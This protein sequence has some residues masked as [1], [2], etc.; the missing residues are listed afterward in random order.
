[1]SRL[2]TPATIEAAPES[3]QSL[4]KA[5][6]QQLGVV[7]NLFRL[8]AVNP[9]AL[10]G[11]LGLSGALS[12]GLLSVALR[13]G[14]ALAI[15]EVNGCEYCLS[16]HTYLGKA[17]AKMEDAEVLANRKALSKDN[18]TGV[19]LEFAVEVSLKRGQVTDELV[20]KVKAAGFSDAE[21]IEII[22]NV[23]LNIWTN[24]LN[25]VANTEVDFPLVQ[26]F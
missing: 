19:A 23:A 1:M 12:K 5:V 26:P 21:I 15:A 6:E 25:N 11:Y 3:S 20:Q 22:L 9:A 14:I 7:P 24:T 18:K 13:E 17:L 2:I 16:A 4:L 8:V 10:E